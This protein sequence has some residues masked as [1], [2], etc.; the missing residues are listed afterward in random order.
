MSETTM[1]RPAPNLIT[2]IPADIL[3]P[4]NLS[5]PQE[6][7][8]VD[9]EFVA[10][11]ILNPESTEVNEDATP[12]WRIRQIRAQIPEAKVGGSPFEFMAGGNEFELLGVEDVMPRQPAYIFRSKDP[13][14]GERTFFVYRSKSEGGLRVSQAISLPDST[15]LNGRIVKGPEMTADS[16]YTQDTQ[17]HPTLAVKINEL[18]NRLGDT[19]L[20]KRQIPDLNFV[21]PVQE[22]DQ[23]V[24]DFDTQ[25]QVHGMGSAEVDQ[26]LRE[27]PTASNF[28]QELNWQEVVSKIDKLGAN[29][30]AAGLVPSF[31]RSASVSH[32]THP[33]LGPITREVYD[34]VVNG[35]SL[36]W[37]M[38]YD[39]EGRV[40][41]DRIRFGD[42]KT[43]AYG[44]DQDVVYSGLL[45]SKPIDY[46]QQ[47]AGLPESLR[48]KNVK[49][50]GYTD[51][52]RFLNNFEPIKKFREKRFA[53]TSS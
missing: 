25:T 11:Q 44:T 29:M 27:L 53:T 17:L 31:N 4:T 8:F 9:P 33:V 14:G 39:G 21:K 37:H 7:R 30:E 15:S 28:S 52:T 12:M 19:K 18:Y 41:I 1:Q 36:E 49:G 38:A 50:T 24:D 45:T 2:E 26:A 16:Q 13:Q 22:I 43:T 46:D 32:D 42:S 23:L 10:P 51:V 40:W 20:A 3:N 6:D 5:P 35:R 48:I 47:T 34:V